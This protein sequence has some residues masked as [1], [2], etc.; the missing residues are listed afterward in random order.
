MRP[1]S[2]SYPHTFRPCL[3][4][5]AG[6]YVIFG[7]AYYDAKANSIVALGDVT[8]EAGAHFDFFRVFLSGL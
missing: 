4:P 8:L 2:N 5:R 1:A 3:W 7:S 6:T